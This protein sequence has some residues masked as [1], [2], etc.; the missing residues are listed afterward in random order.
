MEPTPAP[1]VK[2]QILPVSDADVARICAAVKDSLG[3][4]IDEIVEKNFKARE[5]LIH[6]ELQAIRRAASA[7]TEWEA[8]TEGKRPLGAI[9]HA[10]CRAKRQGSGTAR[11]IEE[12]NAYLG[13]SVQKILKLSDADA[14][15]VLVQGDVIPGFFDTL[16]PQVAF[17]ALGPQQLPMPNRQLT[18]NGFTGRPSFFWVGE[19]PAIEYF[20]DPATGTRKLDAKKGGAILVINNSMVETSV[21][22][23][24][25]AFIERMARREVSIGLDKAYWRGAGTEHQPLGIRFKSGVQTHAMTSTPTI[26]TAL[27]DLG[28]AVQALEGADVPM[29]KVGIGMAPR[30]KNWLMFEALDGFNHPFFLTEMRAGT[31]LGYPFRQSNNIPTNLSTNQSE[32]YLADFE[33]ILV[34][35][36]SPGGVRVEYFNEGSVTVGGVATSLIQSDSQ[37]VRLIV[38]TDVQAIYGQAIHVTTGLTWGA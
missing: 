9:V 38:E 32:L 3:H 35:N 24:I 19:Q 26:V 31:L 13:P 7:K 16:A 29:T 36:A 30:T 4:G 34:G 1:E 27:K 20:S 5:S 21:G 37:A 2:P 8:M 14:G 10:M 11:A 33:M 25:A 12:V 22:P 28:V 17:L 23:Q 18:V 15:G 6:D